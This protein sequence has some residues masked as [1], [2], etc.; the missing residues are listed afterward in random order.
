MNTHN[1]LTRRSFLKGSLAAMATVALVPRHVLH[2]WPLERVRVDHLGQ[3]RPAAG[4]QLGALEE[5]AEQRAQ[6]IAQLEKHLSA[7]PHHSHGLARSERDLDHHLLLIGDSQANAQ[8]SATYLPSSDTFLQTYFADDCAIHRRQIEHDLKV[9]RPGRRY[10]DQAIDAIRA[11]VALDSQKQQMELEAA[12][13]QEFHQ[14]E[15]ENQG[16]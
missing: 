8:L 12:Y 10:A 15:K 4:A 1:P 6:R 16:S 5:L 9:L 2:L 14:R 11:L 7:L 3:Q 13:I